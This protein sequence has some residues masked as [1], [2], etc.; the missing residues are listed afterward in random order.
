MTF[1][2]SAYALNARKGFLIT[3]HMNASISGKRVQAKRR[4]IESPLGKYTSTVCGV[5]R[6]ILLDFI[7]VPYTHYKEEAVTDVLGAVI[8]EESPV[9]FPSVQTMSHWKGRPGSL[10]KQD[11]TE[12]VLR[13]TDIPSS[14]S[15]RNS[16]LIQAV[17][18]SSCAGRSTDDWGSR[19]ALSTTVAAVYCP[20]GWPCPY[21]KMGVQLWAKDAYLI[22]PNMCQILLQT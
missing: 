11:R 14:V 10:F 22:L 3:G 8:T 21:N 7:I 5:M 13:N 20:Y 2:R 1:L 12:G 16:C 17:C 4:C 9:D 15:A 18:C 19:F 6:R